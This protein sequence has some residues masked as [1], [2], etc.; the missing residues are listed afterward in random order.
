MV[1]QDILFP[2]KSSGQISRTKVSTG[3]GKENSAKRSKL[4]K[5]GGVQGGS[6][7]VPGRGRDLELSFPLLRSIWQDR[8]ISSP[9]ARR[10][11][12]VSPLHFPSVQK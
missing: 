11:N 5:G 6:F 9:P 4:G 10:G 1:Q 7:Q 12:A 2:R 8:S 3:A